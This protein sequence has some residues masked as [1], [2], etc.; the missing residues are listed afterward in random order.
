MVSTRQ[1]LRQ[2]GQERDNLMRAF[3]TFHP[4]TKHM[5]TTLSVIGFSTL[6]NLGASAEQGAGKAVV[7]PLTG[8]AWKTE[9]QPSATPKAV[10]LN[11]AQVTLVKKINDYL[12]SFADLQGTFLQTNPDRKRLKGR[13]Y[14]SRP[15]KMR[16][17]YA[18][19]SRLKIVSDGQYLSI[20]DYDLKTVDRYPLES[21]PFRILLR[22]DVDLFRDAHILGIAEEEERVT[23]HMV[24]KTGDT[25]GEIKLHFA[26]PDM[27]LKEW[28]VTDPQG[29]DTRIEVGNLVTGKKQEA[30]FFAP[31]KTIGFS[32]AFEN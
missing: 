12:N 4:F 3:G 6:A 13:F 7:T 8:S 14:V 2:A 11:D 25:A 9:I 17:D 10:T 23:L 5:L 16:F 21:T 18:R 29:L 32:N 1:S 20:E 30:R 27:I 19:P 31:S 26:A 22:R 15:G 28:V 24:D